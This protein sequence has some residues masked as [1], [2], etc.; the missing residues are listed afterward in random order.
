[1]KGDISGMNN[2]RLDKSH[3]E[4]IVEEL[5]ELEKALSRSH[6]SPSHQVHVF[7]LATIPPPNP[8][9]LAALIFVV[10]N[11]SNAA[12]N[13]PNSSAK[14]RAPHQ[15]SPHHTPVP[16]SPLH[17]FLAALGYRSQ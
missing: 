2:M 7:G 13:N 16:P 4:V 15:R 3:Q 10:K 8:H 17:H 11:L 12:S 14:R 5:E 1:M 6:A 9:R